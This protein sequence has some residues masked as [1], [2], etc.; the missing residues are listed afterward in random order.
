MTPPFHDAYGFC[1]GAAAAG[2]TMGAAVENRDMMSALA[3][4]GLLLPAEVGV[5]VRKS[6][7]NMLDCCAGAVVADVGASCEVE[8]GAAGLAADVAVA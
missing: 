3:V 8:A 2:E 6:R 4:W 5:G 7:S 1:A